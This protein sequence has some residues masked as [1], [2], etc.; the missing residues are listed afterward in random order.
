M[1]GLPWEPVPGRRGQ[2]IPVSIDDSGRCRDEECDENTH[3]DANI[4]DEVD[5]QPYRRITDSFQVSQKAIGKYGPTEGCLACRIIQ[6]RGT[7]SGRIGYNHSVACR[8]RIVEFMRDDLECRQVTRKDQAELH[9]MIKN[10][11]KAIEQINEKML[12]EQTNVGKQLDKAMFNTLISNMQVAEIYSPPESGGNGGSHGI[13]SGLGFGFDHA[14][15]G[16]V[17]MGLQ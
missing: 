15:C 11:E 2:I 1:R 7:G 9:V 6:R 12:L 4:D 16:R 5:E 3:E 13:A 8:E 10:V 17:G 14:G